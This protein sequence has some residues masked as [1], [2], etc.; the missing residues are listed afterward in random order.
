M[1]QNKV[2]HKKVIE[3][4][5]KNVALLFKYMQDVDDEKIKKMS[6]VLAYVHSLG[7]T[8]GIEIVEKA[9]P[10]EEEE[11][12]NVGLGGTIDAYAKGRNTYRTDLKQIISNL[13]KYY[14]TTH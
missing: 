10:V 12:I 4:E 2:E 5:A 9:L 8:Q 7:I 3:E 1:E 14:E 11:L 13:K 6:D